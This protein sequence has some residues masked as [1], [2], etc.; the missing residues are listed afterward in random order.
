M[1]EEYCTGKIMRINRKAINEAVLTNIFLLKPENERFLKWEKLL[2]WDEQDKPSDDFPA[3]IPLSVLFIVFVL[4]S[5]LVLLYQWRFYQVFVN[6]AIAA[7]E[8]I[9]D[10]NS[11]S[12]RNY[13]QFYLSYTYAFGDEHY[14]RNQEVRLDTYEDAEVGTSRNVLI[15][16]SNRE[17]VIESLDELRLPLIITLLSFI[18]AFG[19]CLFY[20]YRWY[21][22]ILLLPAKITEVEQGEKHTNKGVHAIYEISYEL[23][24]PKTKKPIKGQTSIPAKQVAPTTEQLLA[25][26]YVS[27]KDIV[28][29]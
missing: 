28:P 1:T 24:S 29:L 17:I 14:T 20:F 2:F 22:P 27:D 8:T 5:S 11:S 23:T 16:P 9:T 26:F 18:L 6:Q 3:R 4:I 25:V 21:R 12:V 13:S 19:L 10:K 7:N 15:L